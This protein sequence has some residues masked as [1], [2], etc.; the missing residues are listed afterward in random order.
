[1]IVPITAIL[2]MII[3]S[4]Y[5]LLFGVWLSRFVME[6][7]NRFDRVE[8]E[9]AVYFKLE[10]DQKIKPQNLEHLK[11]GEESA[12]ILLD[13]LRY[14]PEMTKLKN[15]YCIKWHKENIRARERK[16][17]KKL[18]HKEKREILSELKKEIPSKAQL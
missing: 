18:S 13:D 9:L 5:Q 1:M 8:Y 17:G 6:Y 16:S 4:G 3:S 11:N 14:S 12:R 10:D 15:K 7:K 2:S